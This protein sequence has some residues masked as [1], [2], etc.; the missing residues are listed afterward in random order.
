MNPSL[1]RPLA[2]RIVIAFLLL[3][4]AISA[5]AQNKNASDAGAAASQRQAESQETSNKNA[6]PTK[7]AGETA[8]G[9]NAQSVKGDDPNKPDPTKKD[10]SEAKAPPPTIISASNAAKPAPKSDQNQP[11]SPDQIALGDRLRVL[12]SDRKAVVGE[13]PDLS[14]VVLLLNSYPMKGVPVYLGTEANELLF[15]LVP[16][17]NAMSS[18]SD[19][20]KKKMNETWNALLGGTGGFPPSPRVVSVSLQGKDGVPLGSAPGGSENKIKLQVVNVAWFWTYVV[21][22]AFAIGLFF[23]FA[24]NSNLIRDPGPEPQGTDASK[25]GK[26]TKTYSL[27]RAQF[28]FWSFIIIGAY[29]FIWM[30]T[31]NQ[32]TLNSFT[33]GIFGISAATAAGATMI[34]KSK[35][36]A[37]E[38]SMEALKQQ[39]NQQA[40]NNPTIPAGGGA[41]AAP[42]AA[43]DANA[44]EIKKLDA[45]T[46]PQKSQGFWTDILS[47]DTGVTIHRFQ[48]VAWTLVLGIIFIATVSKSLTMP[49]FDNTLLA[50]MGISSATYVALKPTEKQGGP[51]ST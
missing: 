33:L 16:P 23:Y 45:A 48:N 5:S 9:Q 35:R 7:P 15:D 3:A 21:L 34:D 24:R 8:K 40:A 44:E 17:D 32:N 19:D 39:G 51:P 13:P 29:A 14:K 31:T 25:Y 28:A 43:P 50:L 47:D 49:N 41:G 38:A 2:W 20:D 26:P 18:L 11:A 42:A 46:R 22:L 37:A 1:N 10:G 12:V 36:A 4:C 6:A 30:V 27:A